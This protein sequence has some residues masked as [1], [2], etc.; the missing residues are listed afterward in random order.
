MNLIKAFFVWSSII[1]LA[2]LNGWIRE[3]FLVA[4]FGYYALPLSGILLCVGILII[5]II[6]LPFLERGH[7]MYYIYVGLYWIILTISFEFM[8]GVFIMKKPF[9]E[10]LNAY[11]VTT[12]NL[13]LLVVITVGF[14]PLIAAKIRHLF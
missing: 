6:C 1:P 14:A 5:A 2:I 7:S 4:R 3:A 12:G 8:M 9:S 11:D 13:W 10:L